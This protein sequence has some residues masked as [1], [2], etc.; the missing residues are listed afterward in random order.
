MC[1][2][3]TIHRDDERNKII[4]SSCSVTTTPAVNNV[5]MGQIELGEGDATLVAVLGSCLGVTLYHAPLQIATMAHIV[6][7]DSAGRTST[8]GK[9]ADTAVPR[10]VEILARRGAPVS[11]L[12]AKIVGGA[13]MFGDGGPQQ[14]GVSNTQAVT[15]ALGAMQIPIVAQDVGGTNGRRV[16]FSCCNGMIQI[17]RVGLPPKRI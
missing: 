7:P 13:C 4:M 9:F 17:E 11:A 6:L 12:E 16:S 8:Q 1:H 3:S 2:G 5:S 14:I 15:R 10:M